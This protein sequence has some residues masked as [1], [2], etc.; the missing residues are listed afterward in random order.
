MK[1]H[2]H[3][4]LV[5]GVRIAQDSKLIVPKLR[6]AERIS[7]CKTVPAIVSLI[8]KSIPNATARIEFL[9]SKRKRPHLRL[10][11]GSSNGKVRQLLLGVESM[12]RD[13]SACITKRDNIVTCNRRV[14]LRKNQSSH[15]F[16]DSPKSNT[17]HSRRLSRKR[18]LQHKLFIKQ[19]D[20]SIFACNGCFGKRPMSEVNE[21]FPIALHSPMRLCFAL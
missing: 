8:R 10:N 17:Q 5:R 14:R 11:L 21:F 4:H 9:P 2:K 20:R 3:S 6:V 16:F 15:E 19:L 12:Y 7:R 13:G 1:R 18:V